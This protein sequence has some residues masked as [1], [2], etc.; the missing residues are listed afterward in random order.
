MNETPVPLCLRTRF[1]LMLAISWGV[2]VTPSHRERGR[3]LP[4]RPRLV[5]Y[6]ER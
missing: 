1:Q 6:R 5:H 2:L 4:D 3:R